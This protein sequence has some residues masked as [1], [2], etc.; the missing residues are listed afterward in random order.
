MIT[1]KIR[2][3]IKKREFI[4]VATS[5]ATGHP[6]CAPKLFFKTENN[7]IYLVDYSIGRTARNARVNPRAS[8]AVM[9]IDTLAAYQ[10]NGSLEV[11]EKGELYDK[12]VREL[13]K[14]E[15]ELSALRVIEGM[16]TGKRYEH[17]ELELPEHCVVLKICV[18]EVVNIS[19]KKEFL[20]ESA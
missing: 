8:I 17:F 19:L 16:R 14:K 5:D 2:E 15:I 9:D 13:R 10:L 6:N 1:G 20:K 12:Y 3:L 18:D 7:L 4:N 11:I